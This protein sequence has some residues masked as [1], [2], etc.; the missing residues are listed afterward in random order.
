[1]SALPYISDDK[2]T[3]EKPWGGIAPPLRLLSDNSCNLIVDFN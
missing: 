1:M 3:I 2:M